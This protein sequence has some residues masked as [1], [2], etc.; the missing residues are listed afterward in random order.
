M[1]RLIA[2][3]LLVATAACGGGGSTGADDDDLLRIQVSGGDSEI[4][5]LQ[6]L[7]AAFSKANPG[8]RIGLVPV[9]EQSEHVAK[10][11]AAFAAGNPPDVFLLNYRRFGQFAARDVIEPPTLDDPGA[12]YQPPLEAFTIGGRLLCL[13]Q[14]VS[15]SVVY[16][17]TKLFAQAGV[18]LPGNRW[19]WADLRRAADA[20]AAKGIQAIGYE[21]GMRTV[22]P[23]VWG[24]GGEV[25]DSQAAP[26]K[27]TLSSPQAREALQ[28]LLDLQRPGLDATERAADPPEDRFSRGELAMF[29]DSRRAVPGLRKSSGLEFDVRPLPVNKR[30][31]SLLASDAYCVTKASKHKELA[32]AFARY[33]T[34]PEGGAVLARTGRT[35]PSLKSLAESPA[36]LDPGQPPKSSRV[37]L[38]AI[39]TLRRLPNVAAWNEAEELTDDVLDQLFAGRLTLDAAVRKIEQDT[40]AVFAQER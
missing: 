19:T 23:F 37:F 25:A 27:V 8:A 33:A 13:P 7:V 39:P 2:A 20:F 3:L 29:V 22:A 10:L 15:S 40:A 31:V 26:T 1:R 18:P 30:P 16:V 9:A 38:D 34:G 11:S 6:E 4:K 24:A 14:N 36:F 17:N 12:Y 5:A 21:T 35:V 32:H 28:Y